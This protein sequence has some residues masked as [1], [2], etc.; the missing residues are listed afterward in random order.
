MVRLGLAGDRDHRPFAWQVKESPVVPFLA[1]G[2]AVLSLFLW[3]ARKPRYSFGSKTPG[4]ASSS[5]GGGGLDR[6]PAEL[7]PAFADK[8]EILFSR[9]R[10]LGFDPMLNEGL[11]S[12]ER[13]AR[14]KELG[15]SQAGNKSMHVYG[16]AADILSKSGGWSGSQAL[17]DAMGPIAEDLGLVW[18]GRWSFYDP[19]HV[20]AVAVN[21]QSRLRGL[22]IDDEQDFVSSSIASRAKEIVLV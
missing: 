20:Q 11:R 14:L 6:N 2:A 21:E 4:I 13:G 15:Y 9:L 10:Q 3:R 1:F 8:L 18:G 7:V 17:W 5:A 19:A 22:P 16:V 12:K